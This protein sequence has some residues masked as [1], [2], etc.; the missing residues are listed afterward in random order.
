MS[1]IERLQ[2]RL[3]AWQPRS[4]RAQHLATVANYA[5]A[6]TRD[7]AGDEVALR[8]TSLVYT[9]LLSLVPLLA[10]AFSL[11]KAFGMHNSLQPFLTTFLAPLGA[12]A[13]LLAHNIVGFVNNM[14]V[15][16][17][18]SVGVALLLYTAVTTIQKVEES[19]NSLW[20]IPR[21]RGISQRV[22]RYLSLLI[23]GP[24]LIVS[25]LG[26]A[27]ALLD[28]RIADYLRTIQPFGALIIFFS[29][30][31][32]YVLMSFCFGFLYA[33]IPNTRVQIRSAAIGG[34]VAGVAW[35]AASKIFAVFVSRA[36]SYN[37]VY[38]SF[39]IL[40]Y[41]L[42]WLYVSWII[43]LVGCRLAFYV[44]RPL[45]VRVHGELPPSG[46]RE[47]EWIALLIAAEICDRFL[48]AQPLPT[49]EELHRTLGIPLEH[50]ERAVCE[51]VAEGVLAESGPEQRLLPA[52]DPSTLT[53]GDLWLRARG[54]LPPW[55]RSTPFAQRAESLLLAI[56]NCARNGSPQTLRDWL[57][58][59]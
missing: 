2:D 45:E 25:A 36:T 3:A 7:I 24:V 29:R 40:I 23:I 38:S 13:P 41:L 42:I 17:L 35:Q 56:E 37:A 11:L 6:L 9:S 31:L 27:G 55:G 39:A 26:L 30:L 32:P 50:V 14:R 51:L 16:V 47:A 15:G 46:S 5:L 59:G 58:R 44:E 34:L 28:N 4:R 43:L 49:R 12:E 54:E 21:S 8:A 53:L 52:R 22:G 48:R 33:Y 10:L 1:I 20:R 57:T 18:G 19:F